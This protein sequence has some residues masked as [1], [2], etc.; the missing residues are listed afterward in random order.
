MEKNQGTSFIP[1]S[2]VRAS[3]KPKGIRKVYILTYATYVFF[4]GTLLVS[5]LV[6]GYGY[7]KN[8]QL[9]SE[10]GSL[11]EERDSFNQADMERV[12]ELDSRMKSAFSI[13]DRQVSL[14]S[15]LQMLETKIVKSAYI[16]GLEYSKGVDG[17]LELALQVRSGEFNDALFQRQEFLSDPI[18]AGAII[19]EIEFVQS[20]SEGEVSVKTQEVTFSVIKT[21]DVSDIP[22]TVALG[23]GLSD[24]SV[25]STE[26]VNTTVSDV[27]SVDTPGP[28]EEN[29]DS[30]N[31]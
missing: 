16:Y 1:K 4:F 19:S 11:L 12:Q 10:K 2:P 20:E 21:L 14:T 30:I 31:E 25:D 27:D 29:L 17:S 26:S 24:F 5:V 22:Y 8:A 9:A 7:S 3:S 28:E 13:L 23:S 18:L 6:F 15:L